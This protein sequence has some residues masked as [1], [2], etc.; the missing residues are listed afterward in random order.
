VGLLAIAVAV[1]AGFNGHAV[2]V[3]EAALDT[4]G[5][6]HVLYA[7]DSDPAVMRDLAQTLAGSPVF[8]V[9]SFERFAALGGSRTS[10]S[11]AAACGSP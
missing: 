1:S 4:L 9:S 6:C 2:T 8:S 10:S 5:G 11:K 7:E 3:R